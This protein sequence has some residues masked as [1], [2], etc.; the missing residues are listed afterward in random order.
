VAFTLPVGPR[1]EARDHGSFTRPGRGISHAPSSRGRG[2]FFPCR[3]P[4]LMPSPAPLPTSWDA[5]C[6][7]LAWLR[8]GRAPRPADLADIGNP[9]RPGRA[10]CGT[11]VIGIKAPADCGHCVVCSELWRRRERVDR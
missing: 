3:C 9:K 5:R 11:P 10:L 4:D 1:V 6:L 7:G 2:R 8:A